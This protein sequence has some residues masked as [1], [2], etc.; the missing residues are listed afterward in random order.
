MVDSFCKPDGYQ[1]KKFFE[2]HI[3]IFFRVQNHVIQ[4]LGLTSFKSEKLSVDGQSTYGYTDR[5]ISRP[6]LLGRLLGG[7]DLKSWVSGAQW[8]QTEKLLQWFCFSSESKSA[9]DHPNPTQHKQHHQMFTFS[10]WSSHTHH[11]PTLAWS[12]PH[13]TVNFPI[14]LPV[15]MRLHE[16]VTTQTRSWI[17]SDYLNNARAVLGWGNDQNG[18]RTKTAHKFSI[19][20]KR[21]RPTSKTAHH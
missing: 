10:E 12:A 14:I 1:M 2:G 7:V 3:S 9:E 17:R 20:V 8:I 13:G 11:W 5:Q 19:W 21:P 16:H 18:P 4:K 15:R 6:A